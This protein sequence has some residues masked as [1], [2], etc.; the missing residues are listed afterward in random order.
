MNPTTK[1]KHYYVCHTIDCSQYGN[2]VLAQSLP[3]VPVEVPTFEDMPIGVPFVNKSPQGTLAVSI[4]ISDT[5]FL[6]RDDKVNDEVYE[7]LSNHIFHNQDW[8]I[9]DWFEEEKLR[10]N[11]G[12]A[13]MPVHVV[14]KSVVSMMFDNLEECRCHSHSLLSGHEAGCSY[15][16]GRK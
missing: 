8:I 3:Q 5:E 10:Y 2:L 9:I 6:D 1:N 11:S 14:E 15:V 16:K 12:L 4:K 13:L 7:K